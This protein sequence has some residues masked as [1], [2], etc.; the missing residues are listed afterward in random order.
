L[1]GHPVVSLDLDG[2]VRA[3]FPLR[4]VSA[5]EAESTSQGRWLDPVGIDGVYAAID[6]TDH[7]VALLEESGGRARTVMV[8]RPATLRAEHLAKHHQV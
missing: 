4:Q 7:A 1:A 8:V 2:A 6:P 5:D 3:A